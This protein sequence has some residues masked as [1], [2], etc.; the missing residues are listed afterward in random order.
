MTAGR[1]S[2]RTPRAGLV[3]MILRKLAIVTL[4]MSVVAHTAWGA[5]YRARYLR[6]EEPELLN[7]RI[8][9]LQTG[10]LLEDVKEDT[11]YSQSGDSST[12]ERTFIGPSLWLGMDG[13]VYHPNFV[14]YNILL[15]G[16]YG[17]GEQ[18]TESATTREK[19]EEMERYGRLSATADFLSGKTISGSAFGNYGRSYRE[20]D[21]FTHSD[22]VG[23]SYGTRWSYRVPS[24]D[25][26]AS[27]THTDEETID[28]PSP[29][30]SHLDTATLGVHRTRRD[31]SSSA[32]YTVSQARYASE[33][34]DSAATDHSLSM[35]DAGMI[36][37]TKSKTYEAN[38]SATRHESEGDPSD[39]VSGNL[40]LELLH[41]H[42]LSS[43]HNLSADYYQ[44]GDY[45]SERLAGSA[46]LGHQLYDSLG[47]SISVS[48]GGYRFSDAENDGETR[49]YGASWSEDYRKR[50]GEPR[51]L[52]LNHVLSVQHVDQGTGSGRGIDERH[53]FP[54]PPE[55]EAF[56]L[57]QPDVDESTI[58]VKD[59]NGLR[60]YTRGFDYEVFPRGSRTEIRRISGGSIPQGATV[61][62][63]YRATPGG[64]G[65]YETFTQGFG[66]RLYLWRNMW[67]V[68]GRVNRSFNNAPDTIHAP[69]F[70]T[71]TVG[72]DVRW[73]A[74]QA[75]AE[76]QTHTSDGSDYQS[77]RFYETYY[78]NP[79]PESTLSLGLSQGFVDRAD[80][81]T[82]E[83]SYRIT[84]R[85]FR[86]LTAR[87]RF[88]MEAGMD[89]RRGEG[90]DQ[91][92]AVLRPQFD[93]GIGRTTVKLN[94]DY[95]SNDYLDREE[96]TRHRTTLSLRRDF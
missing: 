91:T 49:Y 72:T 71:R 8:S 11:T 31:R 35:T 69:D 76:H 13:S 40:G 74:L 17:W 48:G 44:S 62:V 34:P 56:E 60:T 81:G 32:T 77:L 82:S 95:E 59:A 12:Y 64:E 9:R 58:V 2:R 70:I 18:T 19:L 94:Y 52:Q 43:S 16:A 21:F 27:Y 26:L 50:L 84:G 61:R 3:A 89:W 57:A 83:E 25:A 6:P 65:G 51:L 46:G 68:Y 85:F 29:Y 79:D 4:A 42:R 55:I 1:R 87:L 7:F 10:M 93:Y 80:N 90:V 37:G 38:L 96:R 30:S 67:S 88:S 63:D 41:A 20:Y 23:D 73:L 66:G 22:V 78:F 54:S 24:F 75:G 5:N 53:T 86:P 39:N 47:S 92:L 33:S 45:R 14:T 15:N 28:S 36:G